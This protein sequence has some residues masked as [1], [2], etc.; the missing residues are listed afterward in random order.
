MV[1]IYT[2]LI[3]CKTVADLQIPSLRSFIYKI[4]GILHSLLRYIQRC[5]HNDVQCTIVGRKEN[6]TQLEVLKNCEAAN[7]QS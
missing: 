1:S 7:L 2:L 5:I 6:W 3:I 4:R